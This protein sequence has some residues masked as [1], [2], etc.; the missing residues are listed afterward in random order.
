MYAKKRKILIDLTSYIILIIVA[1]LAIFPFA[2]G[3]LS[4][5]KS[6]QQIMAY[7]PKLLP[8]PFTLTNYLGVF[9]ET[10]I[11][12]FLQNSLVVT[13]ISVIVS[14]LIAFHSA[15]AL[16]RFKFRGK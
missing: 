8:H 9:K 10:R 3:L 1:L 16:A 2:W 14:L 6:E 15:Y 12:T 7:P 5:L 11:L 13:I 4:S